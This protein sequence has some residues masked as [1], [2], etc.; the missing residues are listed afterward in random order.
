MSALTPRG[1]TRRWRRIRRFVLDRSIERHG[2]QICE[3]PVA[4]SR[5]CGA[6]ATDA[7]H[8]IPRKLWP[9][10]RPGVD[11]P[12]NLRAACVRHNR[13]AGALL[14]AGRDPNTPPFPHYRLE[15]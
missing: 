12:D 5:I 3:Y 13:R 9:A 6:P 11:H 10:G 7:D 1:S 4:G 2:A 15:V 14:R 8:I